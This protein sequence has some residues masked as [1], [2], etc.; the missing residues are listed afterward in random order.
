MIMNNDNK[1]D[2][3]DKKH[4]RKEYITIQQ[5]THAILMSNNNNN[6]NNDNNNAKSNE[7]VSK[8]MSDIRSNKKSSQVMKSNI[9]TKNKNDN[10]SNNN[11]RLNN[12]THD[13][14][15]TISASASERFA[16]TLLT[17]LLTLASTG[18]AYICS[19]VSVMIMILTHN[20]VRQLVIN[21]NNNNDNITNKN[22]DSDNANA[23]SVVKVPLVSTLS[24]LL[25]SSVEYESRARILACLRGVFSGSGLGSSLS[26]AG[27]GSE[28]RAV[29]RGCVKSMRQAIMILNTS[30]T[31]DNN[32]DK[33]NDSG[34]GNENVSHHYD[35]LV[36]EDGFTILQSC[37]YSSH[38]VASLKAVVRDTQLDAIHVMN[39]AVS[40]SDSDSDSDS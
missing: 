3:N 2:N 38:G 1:N 28:M 34:S 22:N 9:N 25:N 19:V 15:S 4:K 27:G 40:H 39:T 36:L 24:S 37:L 30:T 18:E 12:S 10:K 5:L 32:N 35:A 14:D 33:E 11:K 6:N 31:N 17:R 23:K 20:T 26:G 13:N 8:D 21:N 29:V 16:I 7:K